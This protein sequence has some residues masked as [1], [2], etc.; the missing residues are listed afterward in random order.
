MNS[1]NGNV[2]DDMKRIESYINK[3]QGYKSLVIDI[4]GN[5][6]GT[7]EYWIKLVSLLTDKV[8]N[9][10][11][12]RLFRNTS[13][14]ISNYTEFREIELN[15][16]SDL[17][18]DILKNAPKEVKNIFTHFE[19]NNEMIKGKSKNPF[20]G[21]IYLLVDDGVFS[22]G[23]SFAIFCKE[24]KFATIIGT[25]TGGDGYIYDPVLFKLNNSGLIVRMASNMYLTESGICNE[26]EKTVPDIKIENSSNTKTLRSDDSINKILELDKK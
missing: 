4:R 8:Y 23:E 12:Y 10:G 26:E 20:K 19:Y 16:I 21:K 6:G 11:G 15:N 9:C 13:D 18:K 17:S 14:V 22:G 5:Y 25:K 7:D 3:I 2:D 24:Q 1:A